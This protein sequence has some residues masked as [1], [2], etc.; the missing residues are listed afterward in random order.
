MKKSLVLITFMALATLILV[1][2]GNK[3][4]SVK[5]IIVGLDDNYPPMGFR[6]GNN[7]ITGFDVDMAK[8]AS[9]RLG[10]TVEFRPI[11]W[12]SK[13]AELKSGRID[14]LWNGL[15]ITDKRKY[16]FQ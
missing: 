8:E 14:V 4:S 1:G 10:Y 6:D 13:E 7:E 5:K 15:D 3:A 9:K 16:A 2:C 12:N 11:D